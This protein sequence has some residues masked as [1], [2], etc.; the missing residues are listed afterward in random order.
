MARVIN[1]DT[2]LGAVSLAISVV[3]LWSSYGQ[4]AAA[5]VLPGDA[6]PFLVPQ[7]FLYISALLSLALIIGGVVRTV[8]ETDKLA[9]GAVF[10]SFAIVALAA[11]LMK[12]LGYLI[13]APFAVLATTWLLGYRDLRVAVPVSIGS[14]AL[15]YVALVRFANLP[16]PKI[17]FLDV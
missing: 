6:P 11:A 3:L 4:S 2:V 8:P 16:L 7:L 15:L 1:R 13:V 14:V 12:P 9:W 17:P 10:T 5:F